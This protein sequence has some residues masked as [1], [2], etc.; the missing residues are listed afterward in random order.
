MRL[1]SRTLRLSRSCA[2]AGIFALVVTVVTI[3]SKADEIG[4]LLQQ[5]AGGVPDLPV[6]TGDHLGRGVGH[7][8]RHLCAASISFRATPSV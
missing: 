7:A 4:V 1:P 5:A 3:F 2:I 8:T 6:L